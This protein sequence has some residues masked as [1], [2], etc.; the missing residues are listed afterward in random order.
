MTPFRI[1]PSLV[2]TPTSEHVSFS[3]E[4]SWQE[5]FDFFEIK[6]TRTVTPKSD[7]ILILRF[8]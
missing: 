6:Y 5:T 2:A 1:K 4:G 8:D 3:N 7:I